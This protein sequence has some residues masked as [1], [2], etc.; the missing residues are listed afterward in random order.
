MVALLSHIGGT[1][2]GSGNSCIKS[3]AIPNST[4]KPIKLL[5]TYIENFF[6]F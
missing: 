5:Q 2:F 1:D 3:Q 6:T 4:P